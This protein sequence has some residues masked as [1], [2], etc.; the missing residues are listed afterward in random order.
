MNLVDKGILMIETT[1][2]VHILIM[3]EQPV[4]CPACSGR[5]TFDDFTHN[6]VEYQIHI[7]NTEN[8]E[9]IFLVAEE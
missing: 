2:P 9:N 4:I 7:C 8:C 1:N 3:N 6:N 5:T